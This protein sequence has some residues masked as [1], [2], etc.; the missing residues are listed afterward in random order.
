MCICGYTTVNLC[1]TLQVYKHFV[2]YI[3]TYNIY[4]RT[5]V[6]ITKLLM[7]SSKRLGC[8]GTRHLHNNIS[9][10]RAQV[11]A[12]QKVSLVLFQFCFYMGFLGLVSEL[13][14]AYGLNVV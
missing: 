8:S 3:C 1:C 13:I 6:G 12:N 7:V 10:L 4:I 9:D 5:C 2:I 14:D 11:A